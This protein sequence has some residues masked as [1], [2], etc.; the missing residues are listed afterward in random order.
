MHTASNTAWRG[1][2]TP[3]L[4]LDPTSQLLERDADATMTAAGQYEF[5]SHGPATVDLINHLLRH[6]HA[7]APHAFGNVG[8]A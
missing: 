6:D 8:P 3:L 5:T 2:P 7:P 1:E 4:P